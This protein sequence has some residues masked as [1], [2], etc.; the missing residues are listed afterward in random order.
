MSTSN[1]GSGTEDQEE[2]QENFKFR[3][4]EE[5]DQMIIKNA[6]IE[7]EKFQY[8][9]NP[10]DTK[11]ATF[12]IKTKDPKKRKT[13]VKYPTQVMMVGQIKCLFVSWFKRGRKPLLSI[14]PSWPFTIGLLT[15]AFLALFYFLWMLS[16]LQIVNIKIRL[17]AISLMFVNI[18][19]LFRGILQNPGIPQSIID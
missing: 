12:K 16:L 9:L 3:V 8:K 5:E 10:V 15:F 13:K 2:A 18:G 14:G 11:K 7:S 4:T 17:V 1:A 19:F 6:A